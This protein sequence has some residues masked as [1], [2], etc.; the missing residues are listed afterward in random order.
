MISNKK[1]FL[2]INL[3]AILA[4]TLAACAPEEV[5]KTVEVPVEVPGETVIETVE[6]PVEVPVEPVVPP[7]TRRGGWLDT[8]TM[9]VVSSDTAVT[10]IDAG[11]VDLYASNLSTPQD[12]EAIVEAGLER[13]YQFGLYF[14]ITFNPVGPTF[15]G[16]GG[17]NPFS[18]AKIRE[19]M[20]WLIDREYLSQEIYGGTAV[21][22]F[23]SLVSGFP[24]YAKYVDTIRGFEAK[25]AY[26]FEKAESVIS[27]EMEGMG[28]VKNADGLWTYNGQVIDLIFLIRNDSD[29]TRIPI[30]DYVSNQL[31]DI[32]FTVTRDYRTSSEASP[33]WVLGNP[34]DGLWHLYTGAWGS[35]AVSRDDGSDFQF[36]YSPNSSYGFSAL[37]QAYPLSAEFEECS[38]A[39]ANNTF[40]TLEERGE[41]FRTCLSLTFESS[42]RVWVED[43]KGASTWRPDMQVAYD[44]SAGVDI[45]NLWPHTLR[46]DNYEGGVARWGTPDLFVDPP[47]PIAGSNWTYDAQWQ[48]ATNDFDCLPN[49]HTGLSLPQRIEGAEVEI[50]EGL[51]VGKTYDWVDLKF[52]PQIDVP[53]DAWIDWDPL[54]ETFIT[55]GEKYP[56]GLTAKR[57]VTIYYPD[58]LF[59]TVFWHDGSPMTIGDFIMPMIMPFATGTE[60]SVIYDESQAGT[61]ES[62]KATFK[63][64]RILSEDPLTIELYSD[65]YYLD[66]EQNVTPFRTQ[67]W[68]EY[69]YGNGS[70][71]MMA[72]S[73]LAEGEGMLAYSADKADALE[74]EWMSFIGGP[75]LEILSGYLD[76]AAAESYIPFEATLGAYITAEEAASRYANLQAWYADHGHFWVGTG[77]YYLDAVFLVEKTATLKQ[78]ANYVD[79]SSKW[80]GFAEPKLAEVAIDGPGRVTIGE[81]A[82]YDV[83][84]T[85]AGEP[86]PM[87]EISVVKYLL[88]DATG[89]IVEVAE[90]SAVEDGYYTFTLSAD[91]T[92]ML[93]A[94]SNKL[95][96]AV[97]AIP[98][99]IPSFS[100]LEFVTE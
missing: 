56:D 82:S 43:G 53:A 93:A 92:A 35:S 90:A 3:L 63:G 69:G 65:T 94:G 91:T 60:G 44:L 72:V 96:V 50:E 17:L 57:H 86:Y 49:P 80:S 64:W 51:P 31:E 88:F 25:Y 11:A 74:V 42:V 19:A 5:I 18:N 4:L 46:F 68:P 9:S 47:N 33:L 26:D 39:L 24:D 87:N 77:P 84:V 37:W 98:V 13:S 67:F 79:L 76:Q 20:N 95:E 78:N 70:W 1:W 34:D 10:Q 38:E 71:A 100:S 59:E 32:G 14:E 52:S 85:F 22:K 48:L 55:V 54:T 83:F 99:S 23:F 41:L 27:A 40:T 30:G 89:E 12:F 36:F 58:D 81:E 45:N 7:S 61:L 97:V 21:P 6:V 15:T 28:A 29:G 75:S 62:F 73:N 16:T 2:F 8:V 66:A